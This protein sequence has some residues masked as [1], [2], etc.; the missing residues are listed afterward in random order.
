MG[1]TAT[2]TRDWSLK[3]ARSRRGSAGS[4]SSHF[5]VWTP[6]CGRGPTR[7]SNARSS[8][9]AI[10]CPR[11]SGKADSLDLQISVT[12]VGAIGAGALECRYQVANRSARRRDVTPPSPSVRSRSTRRRRLSTPPAARLRSA[13]CAVTGSRVA[14]DRSRRD[15]DRGIR[16]ESSVPFRRADIRSGQHRHR[17][18][19]RHSAR[20]AGGH[21]YVRVRVGSARLPTCHG[22]RSRNA[23]V[24]RVALSPGA[25]EKM[26]RPVRHE[27]GEFWNLERRVTVDAA[28]Y[29]PRSGRCASR[30]A[31]VHPGQSRRTGDP[32]RLTR[33]RSLVDPRR[34]AHVHGLAAAGPRRCR[35]SDFIEWFARIPVRQ[36]QDPVLRR[37]GAAP[38]RCRSTTATASSSTWSPSTTATP[39][40]ASPRSAGG[41]GV[42]RAAAYL[43]SLRAQRL[44]AEYRTADRR[45]FYG[46]LPPSISH[47]GYSAKPMHSYW[48]D[49]VRAAR[50]SGRR[51]P[52][53]HARPS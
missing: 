12:P 22:G 39:A 8:R 25:L 1:S 46:I 24:V 45:E 6:S 15:R 18:A 21:G 50:L 11:S 23:V 16:F 19:E 44:T 43:D 40:I 28:W 29:G 33:L 41:H 2:P 13:R 53:W 34:R 52:G 26:P 51:V 3:T 37:S 14:V 27:D 49:L 9:T 42:A 17:A 20:D 4:R 32:A 38:I 5:C 48:D 31:R 30:P 7:P 35:A 36:R 47:E 10:P